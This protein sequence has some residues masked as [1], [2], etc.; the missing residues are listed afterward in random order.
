MASCCDIS[1]ALLPKL[2]LTHRS[3][4]RSCPH[5]LADGDRKR[6]KTSNLEPLQDEPLQPLQ[7]LHGDDHSSDEDCDENDGGGGGGDGGGGDSSGSAPGSRPLGA[8]VMCFWGD[9]QWSRTQLLGE[10]A[11]GHWGL[12]RA[13]VPDVALPPSRRRANLE[14]RLVYSPTTE[15]TE[16]FMREGAAAM[17]QARQQQRVAHAYI[18]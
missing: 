9:A 7:P 12:C 13:A 5:R 4:F 18:L 3:Y 17:S 10:L 11:R 2:L 1:P 6:L 8:R 16:D 15:M 14:G